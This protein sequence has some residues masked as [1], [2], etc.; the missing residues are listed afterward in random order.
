MIKVIFNFLKVDVFILLFFMMNIESIA[1][2]CV[3]S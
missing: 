3:S 1:V 2:S